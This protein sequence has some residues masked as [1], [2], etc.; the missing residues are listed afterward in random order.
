MHGRMNTKQQTTIAWLIVALACFGACSMPA[1]AQ[2]A[3]YKPEALKDVG[4]EEHL[5]EQVPL[6]LEFRDENDR[7]VKLRDFFDG[8]RP[9]IIT[10]NYYACPMLCT[11]QLNGLIDT[12]Q[13]MDYVPGDQFEIVTISIDPT[14]S[15]MLAKAKKQSYMQQYGKPQAATG[16]HFLT[17]DLK[18]IRAIAAATG[19]KYKWVEEKQQYAHAAALFVCTPDGKL[20]RYLYGVLYEPKTLRLSLVEASEGKIGTTIDKLILYCFHY[21]AAAGTYGAV[22]FH[23]MQVAGVCTVLVLGATLVT[24]YLRDSRRR[25]MLDTDQQPGSDGSMNQG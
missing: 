9:V 19:F 14:E 20:S 7:K 23:V 10:L 15:A 21:D 17:G 3:H 18:N 4:I 24:F 5:D 1:T 13:Q 6:D 25:R 16:W 8:K 22:A 11:L 2:S 12:M